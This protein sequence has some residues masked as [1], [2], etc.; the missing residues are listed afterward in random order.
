M[1]KETIKSELIR[2]IGEVEK[3]APSIAKFEVD[4]SYGNVKDESLNLPAFIRWKI[5]SEHIISGLSSNGKIF[6]ELKTQFEKNKEESKRFHSQS[7]LAHKI[8]LILEGACELLD[9]NMVVW[10]C[11][12]DSVSEEDWV[13]LVNNICLRFHLVASQMRSRY[14][15]RETLV[16]KDEY[17]TQDLLHSLLHIHFDDIRKE[18]WTPSSA[19]ACSR[20]DF[21][22]KH[23]KIIIEVKKTRE[24]LKAKQIG[25]QL[26]IDIERYKVHPD[27]SKL[28]CFV[29]D[30]EGWIS[31]PRGIENDLSKNH[32]G[33]TVSVIIV[34]KRY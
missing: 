24:T 26:I 6:K 16:V 33:L 23:E 7:I 15:D 25:E 30:P 27:C 4:R 17:D 19:G 8:K 3:I 28:I 11:E 20:V 34:P 1:K 9:S 2:L 10:S 5:E 21:L 22:L 18:E 31:N 14:D 13:A 29:Y 12:N 32:E